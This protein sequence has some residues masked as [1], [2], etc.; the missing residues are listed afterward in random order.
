MSLTILPCSDT[1]AATLTH[2]FYEL[3]GNP[4]HILKLRE[5]VAPHIDSSGNI[6]HQ[7]IQYLD[8]LNGVIFET[9]RLHPPVPTALQRLTPPEGLQIGNKYIAG[10]MTVW[11]PQYVIGRSKF[12]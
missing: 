5:E 2:I 1:T 9:L 3:A 11:C 8:H 4:E 6:L 10:N 12:A 7:N